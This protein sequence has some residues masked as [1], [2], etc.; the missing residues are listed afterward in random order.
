MKIE[1][2]EANNKKRTEPFLDE[3][4]NLVGKQVALNLNYIP[5]TSNVK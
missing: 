3:W 4:I 2:S 5:P 1:I